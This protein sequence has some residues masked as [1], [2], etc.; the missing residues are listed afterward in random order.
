MRTPS[1]VVAYPLDSAARGVVGDVLGGGFDVVI[2][3]D[4]AA[5]ERAPALQAAGAVLARGT[6]DFRPGEADLLAGTHLVQFISAGVDHIALSTLPDGVPV[7]A[8]RGAYAGS[9]AE[10]ALAMALAAAKRLPVEHEQLKRGAFHQFDPPNRMLAGGVCGILGFGG[11]G[12]E[13]GRLMRAVGMRVHALNRSGRTDAPV[14]RTGGPQSLDDLLAAADVLVICA[15]LTRETRGL[16]GARELGLMKPDAILVNLAR[17]EI[18]DEAALYAHLVAT[19]DFFA[20]LDAWWVEP[21]RHGRFEMGHPFLD[22]PNVIGSPHNSAG[23]RG[24]RM[25]ALRA[26]VANCRRALAGE[27][28]EHLVRA[29]E[30]LG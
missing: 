4:L 23:G 25:Q 20:C 5:G 7:A 21:V 12:R 13:T 18:L 26:A 9:M 24:T 27:A 11:I 14:D 8:N 6:A 30:R 28:P 22:L 15:A 16:V 3:P 1:L 17:G 19:P 29:D 10:H 2:L